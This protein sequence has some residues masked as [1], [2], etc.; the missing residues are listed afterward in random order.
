MGKKNHSCSETFSFYYRYTKR[1]K[2]FETSSR[3]SKSSKINIFSIKGIIIDSNVLTVLSDR[4]ASKI[5]VRA[6]KQF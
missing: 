4:G 5:F 1:F 3:S 2:I 6:F